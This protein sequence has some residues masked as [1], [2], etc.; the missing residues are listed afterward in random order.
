MGSEHQDAPQTNGA[1]T[2]TQPEG[3]MRAI[4]QDAYGSPDVFRIAQIRIPEVA[5]HQLLVRVHAAGLDRGTW[6]LMAGQPY[7]LR[8]ALGLRKPK[9]PVPGLDLAGTVVAVGSVVTR[10][11]PGDEVF[12][13]G[14]GSFAE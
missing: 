2:P 6:H 3:T 1:N 7:L 13:T 10:F 5:D 4:L 8:L 14:H 11:S 12:G 9:N